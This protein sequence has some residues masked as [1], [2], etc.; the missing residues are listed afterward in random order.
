MATFTWNG[1]ISA[2]WTDLAANTIIF[3]GSSFGA[4]IT[5]GAYQD[6]TNAGNGDPGTDQGAMNNVKYLTSSTMSLNG[7]GSAN[8]TDANLAANDCTLKV[9]F[10]HT[11]AVATTGARLYSYDG[12]T[13]TTE[14]V[15]VAAYA[16][17]RGVSATAWT[18]INSD[19]GNIGGDNSG[20]RLALADQSSGTSHDYY[21]AVSASP[22]SVGAKTSFDLGVALTYS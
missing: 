22:E 11:S 3:G 1:Y 16:F 8:I 13:T 4:N 2:A 20:E 21:V 18:Q 10:S 15:G 17:E 7:A 9:N 14:A 19:S 5:V 6:S 12:T